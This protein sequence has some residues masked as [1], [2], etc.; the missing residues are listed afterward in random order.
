MPFTFSH[1]AIVLPIAYL[2][3][4]F[5]SITGLV[6]GS[7][8]PDFEYFIRMKIKSDY[9]HTI[10][11]VFWF[12]IPLAI[13]FAFVFH[14]RIKASL[15]NNLPSILRVRLAN[16]K[17]F[18]WNQYFRKNWLIVIISILVGVGSHLFWDAFT[19]HTGYFVQNSKV[20]FG[21]TTLFGSEIANYKLLQHGSSLLGAIVIFMIILKLPKSNTTDSSNSNYW[22]VVLLITSVVFGLRF[23][24]NYNL[25]IGNAVVSFISAVI[26]ALIITPLLLKTD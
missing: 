13:L 20:L 14:N 5:Y 23:L 16:Y 17:T 26:I 24:V 12:N 10:V 19:H 11:G 22:R 15:L 6:I 18:N 4:R 9:S 7:I 2:P 25:L 21:H 3:K 8:I 1:P